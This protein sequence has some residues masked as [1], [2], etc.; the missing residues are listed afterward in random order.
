MRSITYK[1]RIRF[2]CFGLLLFSL[3]SCTT[4]GIN[5][6]QLN[7]ISTAQE[8]EMG[9]RFSEEI[10]KQHRFLE[11]PSV[12]QYVQAIGGRLAAVGLD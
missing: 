7:L 9:N 1:T 10:E 2:V 6:G 12:Q 5:R 11:V 8:V 3:V 4:I